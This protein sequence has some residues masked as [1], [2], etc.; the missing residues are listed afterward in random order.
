MRTRLHIVQATEAS[1]GGGA[2]TRTYDATNPAA[3]VW[4]DVKE[5]STVEFSSGVMHA[6]VFYRVRI[7]KPI[8]DF[9]SAEVVPVVRTR[10]VEADGD[11][12]RTF[13]VV[14]VQGRQPRA[15]RYELTATVRENA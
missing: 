15:R 1:A 10:L 8:Y 2:V 6:A 4:A 9:K 11:S 13:E 5:Q 7:R 12:P 14:S 3:T